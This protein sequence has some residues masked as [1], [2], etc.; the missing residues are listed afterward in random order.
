MNPQLTSSF[1]IG[2]LN[3]SIQNFTTNIRYKE[4]LEDSAAIIGT[5]FVST[6]LMSNFYDD[7]N[8]LTDYLIQ[9]AM[10]AGIYYFL[11]KT[12]LASILPKREDMI[13]ILNPVFVTIFRNFL[14]NFILATL[15]KPQKQPDI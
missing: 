13:L 11:N 2:F 1:V 4:L 15:L 14:L 9:P 8:F 7:R 3:F 12:A 5:D 10:N 6:Y